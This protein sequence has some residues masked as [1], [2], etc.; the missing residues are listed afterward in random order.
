MSI[1][2]EIII[3]RLQGNLFS[4]LKM[5]P[6]FKNWKSSDLWRL[7]NEIFE[8]NDRVINRFLDERSSL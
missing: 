5:Q 1:I 8:N 4:H 2:R 7:S 6:L 3:K